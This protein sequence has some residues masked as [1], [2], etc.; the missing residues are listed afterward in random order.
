LLGP[1]R[2][3]ALG[4][5]RISPDGTSLAFAASGELQGMA[6]AGACGQAVASAPG[7]TGLGLGGGDLAAVLV[8]LGLAPA[9]AW[10]HGLPFGVWRMD[11]DGGHLQRIVD[12][13][14]DDPRVAW[15]PDGRRLA[16]FSPGALYIA[17]AR[18]GSIQRLLPDGGYGGLDWTR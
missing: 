8:S 18:G 13:Q 14:D 15:S 17:D 7:S 10:A 1:S 16:I 2:F 9:T 3:L 11:L 12:L 6:D 5:P 4:P